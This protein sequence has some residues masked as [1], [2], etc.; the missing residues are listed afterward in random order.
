MYVNSGEKENRILFVDDDF[1]FLHKIYPLDQTITNVSKDLHFKFRCKVSQTSAIKEG[2]YSV[3]VTVKSVNKQIPTI[4]PND[5][6]SFEGND[7]AENILT[8]AS[9]IKNQSFREEASIISEKIIDITSKI[10]NRFLT[11][12]RNNVIEESQFLKT[13]VI[14]KKKKDPNE[15]SQE[16][17]EKR[18]QRISLKSRSLDL[19]LLRSTPKIKSEQIKTRFKLL[20]SSISPSSITLLENKTLTP[21]SSLLGS[22]SSSNNQQKSFLKNDLLESLYFFHEFENIDN[23]NDHEKKALNNPYMTI[24]GQ[25][26]DD[27]IEVSTNFVFKENIMYVPFLIVEFKLIKNVLDS[28]RNIQKIVIEAVEKTLDLKPYYNQFFSRE[29]KPLRV[30]VSKS[31]QKN[32]N[33]VCFEI[34]N[35]NEGAGTANIYRKSLNYFNDSHFQKITNIPFSTKNQINFYKHNDVDDAIYRVVYQNSTTNELSN[36]FTDVV[37]NDPRKINFNDVMV[38]PYLSRG[39]IFV[40]LINDS[41]N[42]NVV[43]CKIFS[44]NLTKKESNYVYQATF[45]VSKGT[46][47][48]IAITRDL[49][50]YNTYEIRAKLVF[51]NGVEVFSKY[52]GIIQYIPYIGDI[53]NVNIT[54]FSTETDDV[55]FN[56]FAELQQ[57]Q[58]GLIQ[59]LLSQVSAQYNTDFNSGREAEYDKFVA[60]QILRYDLLDGSFEDFGIVPN[61]SSFSDAT[62]SKIKGIPNAIAEKAYTYIISP[63][64]REPS[65]VTEIDKEI[66]DQETNKTYSSNFRKFR[67]PLAL[68]RGNIMS[69]NKVNNDVV[70]DMLYGMVANSLKINV[71]AA[72]KYPTI[73]DFIAFKSKGKVILT[74]NINKKEIQFDHIL[75]FKENNGI[76]TLIGKTHGLKDNYTFFYDLTN[77][78]LGNIR[79]VLTPIEQDYSTGSSII[80]DYV[81][82]NSVE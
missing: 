19:L 20:N 64:I 28:F 26:F 65:S 1:A 82:I 80:S 38:I 11:A 72:K 13:K 59:N 68:S 58:V 73:S 49:V 2:V 75:I 24:V 53:Y 29:L 6:E 23:E 45:D 41:Y 78:D 55:T 10:D 32:S 69:E 35:T 63:L 30:G 9:K 18:T 60:F 7:I 4:V 17:L 34:Q 25:Q 46:Q 48:E 67:H 77:H 54:D 40:S 5:L 76:K 70:P 47:S 66:E 39:K 37:V 71:Q 52:S 56:I 36:D 61:N 8:N 50:F 42:F 27:L 31:F 44:K 51:E 81:L 14:V 43:S 74:W 3:V 12:I 79:F 15:T 57:D 21:Y 33:Y 16:S 22:N 62:I